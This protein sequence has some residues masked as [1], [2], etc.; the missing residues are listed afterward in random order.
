MHAILLALLLFLP[1]HIAEHPTDLTADERA[2]ILTLE[3]E[4]L[5]ALVQRLD[6]ERRE[7]EY[8]AALQR[9]HSDKSA[10]IV[11]LDAANAKLRERQRLIMADHG[12]DAK[13]WDISIDFE[14]V[15]K[16]AK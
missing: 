8:Q 10:A 5:Q 9:A 7:A 16:G 6:A 2:Q 13:I 14:W 11:K 15:L 12:A 4:G 1:D 3:N